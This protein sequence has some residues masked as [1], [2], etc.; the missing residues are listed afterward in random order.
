MTVG[1]GFPVAR[2]MPVLKLL[3]LPVNMPLM[4]QKLQQG[5]KATMSLSQTL[6]KD[7]PLNKVWSFAN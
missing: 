6:S 7:E 2:D 3:Q 4:A 1:Y 5:H